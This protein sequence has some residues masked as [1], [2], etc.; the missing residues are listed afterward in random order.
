MKIIVKHYDTTITIEKDYDDLTLT[1]MCQL[2][3]DLLKGMSFHFD[4]HLEIVEEY[5]EAGTVN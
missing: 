1:D 4:G 5:D 3:E 2:F